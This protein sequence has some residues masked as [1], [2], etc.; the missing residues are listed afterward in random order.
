[1]RA[2]RLGRFPTVLLDSAASLAGATALILP[3][4]H[5]RRE[6]GPGAARRPG[7][8][9]LLA[10]PLSP[11]P[12]SREQAVRRCS[13]LSRHRGLHRGL[14]ATLI[15]GTSVTNGPLNQAKTT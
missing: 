4:P 9:D 8:P 7:P 1:V 10:F 13:D 12:S 14:H 11:N 15:P 3:N 2:E 5:A 6:S